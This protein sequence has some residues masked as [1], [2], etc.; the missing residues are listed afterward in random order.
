MLQRAAYFLRP[1]FAALIVLGLIAGFANLAS[2][3]GDAEPDFISAGGLAAND[4]EHLDLTRVVLPSDKLGPDEVVRLQLIGLSDQQADGVGILQCYCFA[5][6][7]N[8]AVTG[9]LE[10]FGAMVRQGPF[11]CMARPRALLVGRPQIDGHLARILVTVID[12]DSR[13]RAFTFVLGRQQVA[14][15]KDCW[16]TEAVLPA[17]PM[18]N[19]DELPAAPA[20]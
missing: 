12:E 3:G 1:T 6:P 8:R 9:P 10:R 14:P 16:M 13:V 2:R 5:A 15:F 17:L 11:H 4:W 20:I 7:A 18:G 19:P